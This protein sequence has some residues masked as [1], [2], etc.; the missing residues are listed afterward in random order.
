VVERGSAEI[1]AIRGRGTARYAALAGLLLGALL[2]A[3]VGPVAA[4]AAAPVPDGASDAGALDEGRP[5]VRAHLLLHPD[6]APDGPVLRAGVLFEPDPGWH[7]YWRN[8]GDSGLPTEL[9]WDVERGAAGPV[10]WPAPAAFVEGEED[11]LTTYGYGGEVLLASHLDFGEGPAAGRR[12]AVDV[13]VLVC[14]DECIPARLSLE[15]PV[16]QVAGAEADFA[17]ERFARAAAR[18]PRQPASVGLD[19]A[20]SWSQSGIR[21]GDVFRAAVDLLP[22]RTRPS[23]GC[24][25]GLAPVPVG[26]A[27]FPEQADWDL[28]VVAVRPHA[29]EPDAWRVTLEGRRDPDDV[30]GGAARLAGVLALRD[31]VGAAHAVS[32]DLP[33]PTAPVGA[34]VEALPLSEVPAEGSGPG[35]SLLAVLGLALLGGLVLNGMPCVLPVLAIKVFGVAELAHRD[36]RELLAHGAAYT[37]GILA[38]MA[39]LAAAVIA[40]RSAGHSVGWGFQLQEPLFLQAVSA[41]LVAFA[42]NLFGVFEISLA[43]GR[44]AGLGQDAA[45]ARRSFF[46]GLLAVVLATPCSAPFLGT[47]VGF[48]FASSPARILAVFLAIGL[49]LALPYALVTLVPSWRRWIPRPGNWM[50]RLRAGLGFLLLASAIWLL[51]IAGRAG[52]ADAMVTQLV[53]LWAVALCCWLFGLAQHAGRGWLPAGAAVGVIALVAV[54][55]GLNRVEAEPDAGALASEPWSPERVAE[56]L[57]EGRRVL[58]YFTAD[59]CITCKVNEKVVLADERVHETVRGQE[60]AVLRADWTRRDERIRAALAEHG[61]AGVPTTVVHYPEAAAAPRVLPELLTVDRL[62]E[63][64]RGPPPGER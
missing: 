21:P 3:L 27:F 38:S 58:V 47:A 35:L 34:A 6:D 62:V 4:L 9:S 8:P 22:C 42:L 33:V 24:P 52:G 13:D 32:V 31:A 64:L 28:R 37:V 11:E 57:A 45:G 16:A 61:R 59:W 55:A 26:P 5:R 12:V 1:G 19:L 30:G 25:A 41:V 43:T 10:A 46:E 51:W 50:L 39:A 40:L 36:R 18:L 49:G 48:A 53:F 56:R 44:L 17:R 15:R 7:L 23:G 60:V 29:D 2:A 63:A 14:H 54:G 20:A